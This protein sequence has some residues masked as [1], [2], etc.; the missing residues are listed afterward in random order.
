MQNAK[1]FIASTALHWS[2]SEMM[3]FLALVAKTGPVIVTFSWQKRKRRPVFT[4]R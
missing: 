4:P 1:V 2:T 3:E